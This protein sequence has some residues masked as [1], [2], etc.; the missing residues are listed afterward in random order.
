MVRVNIHQISLRKGAFFVKRI[1]RKITSVLVL[2]ALVTAC[3]KREI[4]EPADGSGCQFKSA[5]DSATNQERSYAEYDALGR[6]TKYKSEHN[7]LATRITYKQGTVTLQDVDLNGD[8]YYQPYVYQINAQGFAA[9]YTYSA[10]DTSGKV[11]YTTLDTINY[12]YGEDGKLSGYTRKYLKYKKGTDTL[13]TLWKV[14][15][16]FTYTAGLLSQEAYTDTTR[17]N[18]STS[19]DNSIIEYTYTESSPIVFINPVMGYPYGQ[20]FGRMPSN[21]I[22][23]KSVRSNLYRNGDVQVMETN[24]YSAVVDSKGRP[25]KIRTAVYYP[26]SGTHITTRLYT[27]TCK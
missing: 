26:G 22:P 1:M 23:L 2:V 25:T 19:I 27:Y 16:R 10:D 9:Q 15:R 7:S 5:T 6:I 13:V 3:F 18:G 11:D 17:T 4:N 14:N 20:L 12:A 24:T 21:K 8:P